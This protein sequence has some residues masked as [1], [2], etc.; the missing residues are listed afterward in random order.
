MRRT[1]AVVS[2][3]AVFLSQGCGRKNVDEKNVHLA[4]GTPVIFISVD[5]LRADHLPAYGYGG[6]QTPNIDEL[7]KE[8][9]LYENAY[10]HC[11]LTLPSHLSI[12]TGELPQQH[13]VR[14]NIGYRFDPAA[15]PALPALL[16]N[17]GYRTGASV[18]AYV[19]RGS[20][21]IAGAFDFY[22]DRIPSQGG[23]AVG[24][25]QRPG[26][27]TEGVAEEWITTAGASP[28]F[29][30]LHLFEPHS[31]YDP[32]PPF[33]G[34]YPLAY[35]G[36]I[37]AADAIV[38]K[39]ITFL[40]AR[41]IY[42]RAVIVFFSDHG[43]GL[44]DHGE[45]EH[46]I[47]LYREVLHVPLLL[48]LPNGQ[49]GGSSVSSVVQLTDIVPTITRLLKVKGS[50]SARGV[51]LLTATDGRTPRRVYSETIFPRVHLGWSDLK[52][53]IDEH[54]QLIKAPRPEL[55]DLAA[56]PGEK[57][58]V[59][60]SNRRTYASMTKD[61]AAYEV[62]I[63]PPARISPEEAAKLAALGYIGNTTDAGSGP[64][65]DPKDHLGEINLMRDGTKAF[66]NHDYDAAVRDFREVVAKNP[67][68]TDGWNKLGSTYQE[69][70][71]N[72]EALTAYKQALTIA[73]ELSGEYAISIGYLLVKMKRLDEAE[74]HARLA[75]GANRA[76]AELLKG[77][78]AEARKDARSA[79][80][81]A[82]TAMADPNYHDSA[83]VFL[84]RVLAETGREQEALSVLA[85]IE[86][87]AVSAGRTVESLQM[88]KGSALARLDRADEAQRAFEAEV[89]AF[90]AN[91]EAYSNLA[92]IFMIE[93]RRDDARD[94]MN[95]MVI[96]NPSARA[97]GIASSTFKAFGDQPAAAEFAGRASSASGR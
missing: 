66:A 33:R 62:A 20:T 21:G 64:L 96:A 26:N 46:G 14:N 29:F 2:L 67:R 53:L 73:P 10:S 89:T 85:P 45:E 95:R 23:V 82:R 6:V 78:I 94:V 65:P 76:A 79:E 17:A 25:L 88:V 83:A 32:P 70:G 75:E 1:I 87:A 40:K 4:P 16:K 49:F 22:D 28:F 91:L 55:Y 52:S 69:L 97:F 80:E 86:A 9:V 3:L 60:D 93:G 42:E 7:R 39:F 38:G 5:T 71:R 8:S 30:M 51:S 77:W 12:L 56:D 92:V 57:K 43:E 50:A 24:Q 27:I 81:H 72:E 35:D 74:A 31:P 48:K 63:M 41:G 13:G 36:E 90:P 59:L 37:A 58:N 18:S 84:A 11:P 44:N 61:L 19:L 68:F 15:H 47:L 34:K 54:F